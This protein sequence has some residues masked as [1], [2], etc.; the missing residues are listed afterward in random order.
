MK[1]IAL[2]FTLCLFTFIGRSQC[3]ISII[4]QENIC[5]DSCSGQ[6]QISMIGIIPFTYISV[7]D[8]IVFDN[9]NVD[10][11]VLASANLCAGDYSYTITDGA[12]CVF[13]TTITINESP[14]FHADL[15][16]SNPNTGTSTCDGELAVVTTAG[17]IQPFDLAFYRCGEL[18][19]FNFSGL[20]LCVGD[21]R[22]VVT[23]SLGCEAKTSCLSTQVLSL[24]TEQVEDF[25][26]VLLEDHLQFSQP[27]DQLKI[28]NLSGQILL[29]TNVFEQMLSVSKLL[30]GPY[31]VSVFKDGEVYNEKVVKLAH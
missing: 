20:G 22:A 31:V 3:G 19:P 23:D 4:K 17:G 18:T 9:P 8:T 28:Y 25:K 2:F 16:V 5:A 26:V 21:Y 7:T 30:A 12:G 11:F 14:G 15:I 29:E 1:I 10:E 27:Y 13:D 6:I 24:S